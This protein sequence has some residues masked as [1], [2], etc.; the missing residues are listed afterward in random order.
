MWN[1]RRPR[2]A[3]AILK[4]KS[5]AGGIALSDFRQHCKATVIKTAWHWHKNRHVDQW[6]RGESP[7]TNHT[8]VANQSSTEEA[9]GHNGER[10]SLQRVVLETGAA[11]C[12]PMTLQHSYPVHE[13]KFKMA[14]RLKYKT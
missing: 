5:K 14:Q 6:N 2:I 12:E 4:G 1:Q 10:Q 9:G 13:N 3:K 8:P 7:E 11:T